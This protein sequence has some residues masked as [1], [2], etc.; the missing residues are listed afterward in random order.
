[1]ADANSRFTSDKAADGFPAQRDSSGFE[2]VVDFILSS[3]GIWKNT[4][5]GG[6]GEDF[7]VL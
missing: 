3:F 4:R 6:N 1:M 2:R 7:R 5:I